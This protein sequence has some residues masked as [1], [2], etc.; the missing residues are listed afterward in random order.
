MSISAFSWGSSRTE[1]KGHLIEATKMISQAVDAKQPLS[2]TQF[3]LSALFGLPSKPNQRAVQ[4]GLSVH[5][6]HT[7]ALTI[8]LPKCK[9]F[10]V[11]NSQRRDAMDAMP[12][13]AQFKNKK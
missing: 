10:K 3:Q 9:L 4:I 6:I 12:T 5:R 13:T 1:A 8:G 7:I 11:A 2:L